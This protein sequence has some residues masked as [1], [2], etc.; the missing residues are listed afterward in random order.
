VTDLNAV[1]L[2]GLEEQNLM[3]MRYRPSEMQQALAD[4]EARTQRSR[5]R[6]TFGLR[7]P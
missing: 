6:F 4:W 2:N 1:Y 7:K 5:N 3:L